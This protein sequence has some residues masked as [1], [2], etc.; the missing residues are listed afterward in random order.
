MYTYTRTWT[1]R[2]E[3]AALAGKRPEN[4]FSCHARGNRAAARKVERETCRESRSRKHDFRKAR[5]LPLPSY[6]LPPFDESRTRMQQ[7]RRR[8]AIFR[9]SAP[10]RTFLDYKRDIR[11]TRARARARVMCR[12]CTRISAPR[13]AANESF[14]NGCRIARL[15]SAAA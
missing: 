14:E 1:C 3:V 9:T 10:R 7:P 6:P 15:T 4:A 11:C 13:S 2:R 12:S 5:S 8:S